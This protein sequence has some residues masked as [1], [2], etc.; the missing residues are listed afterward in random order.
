MKNENET[1]IEEET[2]I[3]EKPKKKRGKKS[4]ADVSYEE[5]QQKMSRV[6]NLFATLLKSKKKYS[7]KDFLDE[8]KDLVRLSQKYDI[9]ATILT[10]LDPLF[11]LAG[12]YTKFVE[13]LNGREKVKKDKGGPGNENVIYPSDENVACFD[14]NRVAQ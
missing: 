3:E 14:R 13:M 8:S 4:K 7:E 11:L 9:V 2:L 10:I 1:F 5:I 6:F 12:F